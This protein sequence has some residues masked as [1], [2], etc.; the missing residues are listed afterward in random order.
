MSISSRVTEQGE[1][2][3]PLDI[4]EVV[5]SVLKIIKDTP[6]KEH[7]YMCHGEPH[8]YTSP[9]YETL[10]AKIRELLEGCMVSS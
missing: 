7:S 8:F 2:G 3:K 6:S 10:E 4:D 1:F 9:D 5:P